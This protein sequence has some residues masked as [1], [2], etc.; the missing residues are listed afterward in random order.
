MEED[1]D[2][3]GMHCCMHRD[4]DMFHF[5]WTL[6]RNGIPRKNEKIPCFS[7]IIPPRMARERWGIPCATRFSLKKTITASYLH[8]Y[9]GNLI[10]R[11]SDEMQR[12]LFHRIGW[13]LSDIFHGR[14]KL[15]PSRKLFE[16]RRGYRVSMRISPFDTILEHFSFPHTSFLGRRSERKRDR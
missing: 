11:R 10:S 8:N 6:H 12:S 2:R 7:S 3:F 5:R 14:M 4:D 15:H 13:Y 1:K 16:R 9:F